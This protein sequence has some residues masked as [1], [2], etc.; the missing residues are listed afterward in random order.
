MIPLYARIGE[1]ALEETRTVLLAGFGSVPDGEYGFLEYYCDESGCDCRRVL[2]QVFRLDTGKKVWATINYGWESPS[3]YLR[4]TGGD[5]E[6]AGAVLDPLNT[7]TEYA[8]ALLTVLKEIELQ[9][10]TYV[11]R[12]R[13]HYAEFKALDRRFRSS[14]VSR[15]KKRR[16]GR[17]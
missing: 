8:A 5:A 2:L 9:D 10:P 7:Q 15:T 3:F 12:L 1:R 16:G 17:R 11:A 14:P 4:W 13:R 6:A